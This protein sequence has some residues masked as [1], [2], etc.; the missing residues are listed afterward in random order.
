MKND[1]GVEAGEQVVDEDAP[2]TGEALETVG[3][4]R[5]DDVHDAKED[6]AGADGECG[7]DESLGEI[8]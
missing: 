7:W 5:L 1:S 6:E 4:G 8:C 2:S 3:G